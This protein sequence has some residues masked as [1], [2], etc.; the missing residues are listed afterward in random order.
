MSP[1]PAAFTIA[2]RYN[3]SLVYVKNKYLTPGV[4][5]PKPTTEWPPENVTLLEKYCHWRLSGGASEQTT[6]VIY[7][8]MAGHVLG[9]FL[10][11]HDDLDLEQDF[12]PAMN[13]VLAK[14]I[15][16]HWAKV[17][18]NGLDNF[19]RFLRQERGLGEEITQKPFD[20]AGYTK[21][22]PDWLVQELTNYQIIQQRNWRPARLYGSIRRFWSGHVRIWRFLCEQ[23]GVSVIRD[24]KRQFVFDYIESRLD[25]GKAVSGINGDIRSF[26]AFLGFLHDQGF[27]V[28]MV[29]LRIPTIQE[30]D[31]LPRFMTD[32][33]V[34]RL[35]DVFEERVRSAKRPNQRRDAVMDRAAFYLLWQAGLRL[36]E[37]GD[38]L[39]E[40]LDLEGS[41]IIVRQGKGRKD[42]P[43]YLTDVVVDALK[44]Y[45]AMRGMAASDHVFLYRNRPVGQHLIQSRIK[46]GGKRAKVGV[47]PHRLRHTM[48][49]QLLNAGCRIT[50]LQ[51]FLGHKRLNTT[52]I[53]A[54]VHNHSVADDYYVAMEKIEQRLDLLGQPEKKS[55]DQEI[56]DLVDRLAALDKSNPEKDKL[57]S[58]IRDLVEARSVIQS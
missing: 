10:R 46:A 57:V 33:Q 8:P 39:L 24:I 40:D 7:M 9:L 3:R 30:G 12:E 42:R 4:Q 51:V 45:L 35:R 52:M 47:Y 19:R 13:Y 16:H 36:G 37:V 38:L 1:T 41:K 32:E 56:L 31:D 20:V 55:P 54:R 26:Q 28:P 25:A 27:K 21:G 5:R 49:T 17:S 6:L 23:R 48:A 2:E 29:L 18:R 15:G 50:S 14:G 11:P 58:Q 44:A 53:Y 34:C 22:L 43:V